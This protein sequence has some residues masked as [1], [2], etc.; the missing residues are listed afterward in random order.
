MFDT[1]IYSIYDTKSG[2]Y[3]PAM[4][5]VNDYTAI[6][7]FQEMLCSGDD[8]SLLSLYPS[9]Y[10]LFCLGA[11]NQQSGFIEPLAAP[12]NVITGMDAF[13]RACSEAEER[14][15]RLERLRG[16]NTSGGVAHQNSLLSPSDEVPYDALGAT[17]SDLTSVVK[18]N[19]TGKKK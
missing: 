18:K 17:S 10:I 1:R 12:A 3:G 4:T 11:F 7:S 13:T 9:D 19:S 5:F 15:S 16:I 2:M 6:R 14:R 8:N